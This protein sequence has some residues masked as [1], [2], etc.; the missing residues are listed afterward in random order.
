MTYEYSL[1]DF[2]H[3]NEEES[4][5]LNKIR[6]NCIQR[7]KIIIEKYN[8]EMYFFQKEKKLLYEEKIKKEKEE[9]ELKL[10]KENE[11]KKN[12]F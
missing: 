1:Y 4:N 9:Q 6:E 2:R 7:K 11:L 12:C 5:I 3:A 10:K 8:D